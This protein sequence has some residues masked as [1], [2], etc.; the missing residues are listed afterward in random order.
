MHRFA[1]T[2]AAARPA[3][4]HD[5]PHTLWQGLAQAGLFRIGLPAG[6]G[7]SGGGYAAIAAGDAA[8]A[9][10]GAL[11]FA[12]S[13]TGHQ[14]IA[15]YFIAGHGSATQLDAWLPRLA[16][17]ESTASVAISEPGAGAHPKHLRTR[18]VPEGDGW[19]IDGEK[20]WVTNGPIADL[21]IVLAITDESGGRK[22]YSMFL[23]PADTPGL[24]RVAM[25]PLEALR[26]S[27]HCGL[28]L[29]DV[30]VPAA[31]ML[32]RAGTAYEDMALHFRT[33]EDI[34]GLSGAAGVLGFLQQSLGRLAG[35]AAPEGFDLRLGAFSGLVAVLARTATALAARLDDGAA[36]PDPADPLLIGARTLI[37]EL[38]ARVAAL[39]EALPDVADADLDIA[40]ADLRF[41]LGIA[42]GPRE[43]R[44]A[45]LGRSLMRAG[46]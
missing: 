29:T 18:A 25:K 7:G 6:H 34:A 2:V 8:I 36:W 42:R 3:A 4:T 20:A 21:F 22:R 41:S 37:A 15:R 17:G 40:I 9:G 24:E 31:A 10:A 30:R 43:T 44:Q 39:R 28:K 5:F 46:A 38:V 16:A 45:Q 35:S 33:V 27:P 23:M 14:L 26:P 1:A 13:W 11:G 19:R 12:M 32:G